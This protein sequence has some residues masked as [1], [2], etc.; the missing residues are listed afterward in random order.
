MDEAA[1]LNI[2]KFKGRP[3]TDPL[4][5]H[6]ATVEAAKRLLDIPLETQNDI[7]VLG[8]AF[9]PG[10]LTIVA[11]AAS[12]IPMKGTSQLR[13]VAGV[14]HLLEC[15]I[16]IFCSY[17]KHGLCWCEDTQPPC[18]AFVVVPLRTTRGCTKRKS[19]RPCLAD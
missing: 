19:L 5:V 6:V 10:P 7:D 3:L 12:T 9:W 18:S 1:V 16:C 11:K 15:L 17:G 8:A 14:H 2:F 13:I 4:I